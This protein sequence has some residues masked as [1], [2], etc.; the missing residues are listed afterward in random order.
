MR[1]SSCCRYFSLREWVERNKLETTRNS[2]GGKWRKKYFRRGRNKSVREGKKLNSFVFTWR[3]TIDFHAA[4][5]AYRAPQKSFPSRNKIDQ[6]MANT[7]LIACLHT[8]LDRIEVKQQSLWLIH[9]GVMLF[10]FLPLDKLIFLVIDLVPLMSHK[11]FLGEK[12]KVE[13]ERFILKKQPL[14][15][16]HAIFRLSRRENRC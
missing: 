13:K 3:A 12:V 16:L 6:S 2:H 15:L 7:S 11:N 9:V 4:R 14:L 8:A 5:D 10:F 1:C